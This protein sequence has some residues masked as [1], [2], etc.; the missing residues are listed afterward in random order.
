[1][2]EIFLRSLY[3]K[4]PSG[5]GVNPNPSCGFAITSWEN[6]KRAIIIRAYSKFS[7]LKIRGESIIKTRRIPDNAE[8]SISRVRELKDQR[9]E[10]GW[11]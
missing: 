5:L 7:L 2:I 1:M 9:E 4:A 10:T 8:I 6:T 3:S 11:E